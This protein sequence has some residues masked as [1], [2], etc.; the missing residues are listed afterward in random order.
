MC[1][2]LALGGSN[3][4]SVAKTG[5]GK[6]LGFLIPIYHQMQSLPPRAP[7]SGPTY[8]QVG[9][10]TVLVMAPTREL[11]CQIETEANKFGQPLGLKTACCYG[12]SPKWNQQHALRAGVDVVIGTPGRLKDFLQSKVLSLANVKFLVLDE[13][14][15]CVMRAD[16]L[17]Q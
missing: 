3:V 8:Q 6:T 17:Q 16:R 1:W 10:P 9:K 15:R 4:V 7:A 13:A 11:A 2:P 14:D 12:G 5:S